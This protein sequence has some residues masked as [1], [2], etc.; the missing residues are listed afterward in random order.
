MQCFK[1][2]PYLIS[3]IESRYIWAIKECGIFQKQQY[4]QQQYIHHRSHRYHFAYCLVNMINVLS[5]TYFSCGAHN[6]RVQTFQFWI[7]VIYND[8]CEWLLFAHLS[9][10]QKRKICVNAYEQICNHYVFELKLLE[11]K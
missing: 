6:T 7:L 11:F 9:V 5:E 8:M 1:I 4:E 2:Y 10:Y 3:L